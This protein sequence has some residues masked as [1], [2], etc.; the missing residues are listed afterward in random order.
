MGATDP[1]FCLWN[2]SQNLDIGRIVT[3]RSLN[4]VLRFS[5]GIVGSSFRD[6]LILTG[7]CS[8]STSFKFS[9]SPRFFSICS[10]CPVFLNDANREHK[11]YFLK[12]KYPNQS[13]PKIWVY[14]KSRMT[15]AIK[16]K[17]NGIKVVRYAFWTMNLHLTASHRMLSQ[18]LES[19]FWLN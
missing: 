12:S 11:Q 9:M 16:A 17:P 14:P 7:A 5:T 2:F 13:S 10:L 15:K 3:Y 18:N 1:S 6:T 8:T 4:R 19:D